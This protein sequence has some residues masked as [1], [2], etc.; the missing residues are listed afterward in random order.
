MEEQISLCPETFSLARS[1]AAPKPLNDIVY[2]ELV[3]LLTDHFCPKPNV[4]V[5]IYHFNKRNQ[6]TESVSVYVAELRK[7][8]ENCEF[9]DLDHR[10]RDRLVCGLRNESLIKI[11]LSEKD[12]TF[13]KAVNLALCD[14]SASTDASI[15]QEK[16]PELNVINK[17]NKFESLKF[18][19][20]K[21]ESNRFR[22]SV[23][24][25][26][27]IRCKG[28]HLP[29]VCEFQ[30]SKCF[31]NNNKKPLFRVTDPIQDSPERMCIRVLSE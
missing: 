10:L 3:K 2:S 4:I 29:K 27:C 21:I 17:L 8:S 18:K 20:N 28:N 24:K 31:N 9:I 12:L 30:N 5:Q 11:L 15:L 26:I 22:K 13:E 23:N 19:P 25:L 16:I 14:E 7:L 1:L 6:G